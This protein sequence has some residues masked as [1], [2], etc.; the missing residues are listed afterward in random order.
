MLTYNQTIMHPVAIVVLLIAGM[1]T[2]ALPRRYALIPFLVAAIF[3]PMQQRIVIATLD[4]TTLR[5][6]VLFGWTRLVM[7]HEY[8]GLRF[9]SIDLVMILWVV[10]RT[11]SYLL[12]WQTTDALIYRLGGAFDAF[13]IY[14]LIRHLVRDFKDIETIIKALAI[15][16]IPLALAMLVERITGRNAL[17]VFGGVPEMTIIRD[18]RLRSQGAFKHPILAGTFGATLLPLFLSLWFRDHQARKLA[19][20]GA[21]AATIITVSTASSG[22]AIAFIVGIAGMMMWLFRRGMSVILWGSACTLIGLHLVMKA[23]VW[24]LLWRFS[25]FGASTGYHRYVL[26]DQFIRRFNEWWLVGTKSHADWGF[27]LFDVTNQY[28]RVGVDGGFMTLLLFIT[29]IILCFKG[30]GRALKFSHNQPATQMCLW[31]L[32]ASLFAHILSFMSV[33]YFDQIIV[34]WYML[35][36]V[37]STASMFISHIQDGKNLTARST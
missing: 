29:A 34:I 4:F 16:C 18:G 35:L 30:L 36:A 15:I 21:L 24:A 6:L 25:V 20:V 17:A 13:G 27:Y 2:I 8:H 10:A 19:V 28:V 37:I 11:V 32:G 23:P 1:L 33:S 14:F 9:N 26:V 22:P 7:R 12:L 5:I 3:I 31:A